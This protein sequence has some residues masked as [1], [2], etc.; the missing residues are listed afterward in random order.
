MPDTPEPRARS[1]A[2]SVATWLIPPIFAL[3]AAL[4]H[5][6]FHVPTSDMVPR[7][8]GDKKAKAA[9]PKKPSKRP[10]KTADKKS[11]ERDL[12]ELERLRTRW[13]GTPIDDE[14]DDKD[15][16]R[17]HESLLRGAVQIAREAGAANDRS[18]LVRVTPRCHTIRCTI[19]V[20]ADP[21]ILDA[22]VTYLP[23]V[24]SAEGPLWHEFAETTLAA[25]PTEPEADPE[26]DPEHAMP[27]TC[28]AWIVGFVTEGVKRSELLVPGVTPARVEQA[29]P[30]PSAPEP[31]AP[32]PSTPQPATSAPTK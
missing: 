9:K 25:P 30:K 18:A 4:V 2:L 13:S 3:A 14:P 8:T 21:P 27:R 11:G 20:C 22:L 23:Q 5:F 6:Q 26:P 15:F 1:R 12:A 24:E 31:S 17:Q 28:K 10:S 7:D 19:E 29:S 32:E 16:R